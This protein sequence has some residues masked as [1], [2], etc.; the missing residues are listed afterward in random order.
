T[1]DADLW[2]RM[3]SFKDHGKSWDAIHGRSHQPGFRWV[4]ESFG[5]NWRMMEIQAAIGRIQLRRMAEWTHLRARNAGALRSALRPFAGRGG[6]IRLA[7]FPH[8]PED[9]GNVHAYYKFYVYVRP[10]NLPPGWT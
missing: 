8:Q 1:N 7:E 9:G 5:T 4:H 2:A 6:P 10:E 3:W